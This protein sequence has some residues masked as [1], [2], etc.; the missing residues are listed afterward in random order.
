MFRKLIAYSAF[1]AM[2][3]L[4]FVAAAHAG[5]VAQ[6]K[7]LAYQKGGTVVIEEYDT[8][9]TSEMKYGH[10]TGIESSFDISKSKVG[11]TPEPGDILRVAYIVEGSNKKATKVMNVS[12]QDVMKK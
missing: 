6:G 9:I 7:C 2:G 1:M 8:N 4:F 10:P 12:K 11:M 3:F 5:E